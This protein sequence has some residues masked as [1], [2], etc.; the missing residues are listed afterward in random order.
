LCQFEQLKDSKA[1][2]LIDN[3]KDSIQAYTCIVIPDFETDEYLTLP[4]GIHWATWEEIAEGL[5]FSER[6]QELLSGLYLGL[7][8]LKVAGCETA[9]LD[10]SFATGKA[11]PG[12]FDVCYE[13]EGID[14]QKLD[15]T[16]KD[17][18]NFRAKQKEKYGGEFF[19]AKALATPTGIRFLEFFQRNKHTQEAKGILA[20]DLRRLS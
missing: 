13:L 6:R 7:Q 8:A 4:P 20:I 12:D 11:Q 19:P 18:S 3:A 14:P 2:R 9:Y 16:L 15:S 10:G 5:G 17:F 1:K